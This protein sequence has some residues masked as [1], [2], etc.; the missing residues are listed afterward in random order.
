M[1]EL[2]RHVFGSEG[3]AYV[4]RYLEANRDYESRLSKGH[5]G[6]PLLAHHDIERGVVWSLIPDAAPQDY[7]ARFEHGGVFEGSRLRPEP[8]LRSWLTDLLGAPR[9][10]V[11][12]EHVLGRRTDSYYR[13]RP[14]DPVVFCDDAPYEFADATDV[15]RALSRLRGDIRWRPDLAFVTTADGL[16]PG[17]TLSLDQLDALATEARA[18]LVGAWDDTGIICWEPPRDA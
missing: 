5:A 15:A 4:R 12:T 16:T 3:G 2:V 14:D 1:A 13:L 8:A 18:I 10:V 17:L 9:S 6:G 7:V 11:L